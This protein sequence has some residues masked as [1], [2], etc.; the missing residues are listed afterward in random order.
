MALMPV[1]EARARVLD[2]AVPLRAEYVA[3]A[4]AH[5]RVLAADLVARRT[6]P[7][8]AV[9]AMDGYAVRASDVAI[10]PATLRLIGESAAGSVFEGEVQAGE[11]VRILTGGVL[12][13][14]TDTI[15]IQENVRREGDLVIVEQAERPGRFVRP[16]G[17]DFHEG[18]ARLARGRRLTV[19]DA[20]L[21]AAMNHALVPVHRQP[22][23]AIFSTGDELKP[24]GSRL[25]PGQVISSNGLTLA[26][27]AR[28]EGAVAMDFGIVADR[29]EETVAAIR[30]ARSWGADVLVT[31]GGASVGDYDLVQ[32]ALAAE[33][34]QLAVWRI[35]MRP[36]K[37][38][39]F[40]LVGDMRVLGMP[41]NPVSSYVCSLLF[42]VPLIRQ[43][44]GR[45]TTQE[46]ETA[47]LG[48]DLPA[49]DE[50]EDYLR[51]RLE[52]QAGQLVATPLAAQDSSMM[53]ALAA[54]DCLVVRAPHAPAAMAG[55]PCAI[56]R[57]SR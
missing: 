50:R 11:T 4:A 54:A 56:L 3:V 42:L 29:L 5:D 7:P 19:R 53:S 21:A 37:P 2:G 15:V 20:A 28:A 33:G 55:E 41:G 25:G 44:C 49:N 8:A 24:P 51:S 38:F 47:V 6:Q 52:T 18:D 43:L 23:V 57:L 48:R 31:S 39:M 26:A 22:R 32:P 17:L 9:S 12:P 14:G 10:A 16:A 30:S 40:G 36:G 45:G 27:I 35:A 46:T 13:A 1:E 34:L